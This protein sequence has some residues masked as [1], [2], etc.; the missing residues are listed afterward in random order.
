MEGRALSDSERELRKC[1]KKKLLE[2][3]S[4]ERTI[5]RQRSRLLQLREGD[6]N[7]KI[8]HQQAS[9]RQRK[10]IIR[11]VKHNGNIYM[12]GRTRL[13]RQWTLTLARLLVPRILGTIRLTWMCWVCYI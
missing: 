12:L 1:L 4:L 3:S 2:L 10:N 11:T 7:T 6:G 5:A 8:F 9:H 13:R